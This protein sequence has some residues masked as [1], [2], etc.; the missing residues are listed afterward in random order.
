MAGQIR[1]LFSSVQDDIH[2]LRKA[3]MHSNCLILYVVLV[4][5]INGW[6]S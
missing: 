6:P 4:A 5:Y 1:L 2:A 3:H